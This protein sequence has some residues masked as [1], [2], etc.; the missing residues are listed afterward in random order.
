MLL[1]P[2]EQGHGVLG[3]ESGK[4]VG[5]VLRDPPKELIGVAGVER[6]VT[7]AGEDVDVEGYGKKTWVPAFAGMSGGGGVR[8][9]EGGER[10]RR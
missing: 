6:S 4:G 9:D 1:E 3:G 5:L 7:L 2:D 10:S 8:G